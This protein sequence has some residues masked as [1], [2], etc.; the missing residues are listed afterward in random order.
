VD[1][2]CTNIIKY[3]YSGKA[4][5]ITIVC[6]R[7]N[8]ELVITIRDYGKSFDP[9]SVPQPDL[10]ADLDHRKVGGLGIYFMKKLMDDVSYS[11]DARKGNSLI[12]RRKLTAKEQQV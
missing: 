2:A 3:A 5:I 8:D 12:M 11:F 7:Q 4:G 6:E 1:E 10:A 9:L